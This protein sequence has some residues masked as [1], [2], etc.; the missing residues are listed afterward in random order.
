MTATSKDRCSGCGQ[1]QP[2][3]PAGWLT[4]DDGR[5]YCPP[6]RKNLYLLRTKW[7]LDIGDDSDDLTTDDVLQALG[8]D[9]APDD[10]DEHDA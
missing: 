8:L 9:T 3:W 6:C 1:A 4:L 2:D 10:G 5:H 7:G